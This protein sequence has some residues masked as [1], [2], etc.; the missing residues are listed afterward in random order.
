V[1][2]DDSRTRGDATSE[3][4]PDEPDTTN[5]ARTAV[6]RSAWKQLPAFIGVSLLTAAVVAATL[7]HRAGALWFAAVALA[8]AVSWWRRDPDVPDATRVR[9][10]LAWGMLVGVLGL[11]PSATPPSVAL[12]AQVLLLNAAMLVLWSRPALLAVHA[13]LG[14][15]PALPGL[16]ANGYPAHA[17]LLCLGAALPVL[18]AIRVR[19]AFLDH[20]ASACAPQHPAEHPAVTTSEHFESIEVLDAL[21]EGGEDT[22]LMVGADGRIERI[23]ALGREL[24]EANP[25]ERFRDVIALVEP[26]TRRRASNPVAECQRDGKQVDVAHCVLLVPGAARECQ[27]SLRARPL[28]AGRA[29]L[30]IRDHTEVHTLQRLQL[31]RE[32]RDPVTGLLN[33]RELEQRFRRL[34]SS[35]EPNHCLCCLEIDQVELVNEACGYPAGDALLHQTALQ[36]AAT[37]RAEDSLAR[38]GG[39]QFA[40]LLRGCDADTARGV[41]SKLLG[42]L[43]ATPFPWRDQRFALSGRVGIAAFKGDHSAL[44]DVLSDAVAACHAARDSEVEHI[45]VYSAGDAVLS[46]HAEFRDW[47]QRVQRAIGEGGFELLA[48]DIVPVGSSARGSPRNAELLVRMHGEDGDLVAPALFLGA[49]E[50]LGLMPDLDRWVIRHALQAIARPAGPLAAY[51]YCAINL[52]G[53]SLSQADL[54]TFIE[55]ELAES[56]A[57]PRRVCF[58]ITETAVIGDLAATQ[59]LMHALRARGVRFSLDDFGSGL[60]SYTY[61]KQLPADLLK[62]DGAFVRGLLAD[63]TDRAVVESINQVAHLVGMRTI[64]EYVQNVATLT[65]LE[66]LRVDF[67]QGSLFGEPRRIV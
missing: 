7:A 38:L 65:A 16:L 41:A 37:A 54:L 48:Q 49:T 66:Q 24:T 34:Q 21:L 47:M 57:D 19:R 13:A 32:G 40:L 36:L 67:A 35:P 3:R 33:R 59:R 50:R 12:A 27:V 20:D 23:N 18:A 56:G 45:H 52:S 61:L 53:Q 31:L 14:C 30:V 39:G 28:P 46:R 29:L 15:L 10:A 11:L 42:S 4:L 5:A 2:S 9:L 63:T 17:A 25:G 55:A 58:E 43:S 6:D 60:S 44:A 51:G 1:N 64:A 62:I 22:V 26:D 8:A